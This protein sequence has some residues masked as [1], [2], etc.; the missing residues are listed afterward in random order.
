[1]CFSATA[2]FV[3]AGVTGAIGIAALTRARGVRE[4]PLAATP[5]LFAIQQGIEGLLWLDLSAAPG[6]ATADT[7]TY[8]FLLIAEVFWPVYAPVAVLL[9]EPDRRRRLGMLV[10]LAAGI[11]VGA[12]LRWLVLARPHDAAIIDGHIVYLTAY[13]HSDMVTV[14]YF[15]ATVLALL[16][17]SHRTVIGL[18][19]V[20]LAGYAVSYFFYWQAFV[21]VWCFFAAAASVAILGHFQYARRLEAGLNPA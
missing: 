3:T 15:L 2:S 11:G 5:L 8:L 21:S 19:A 4:M 20:I 1:M 18:G 17:S 16:L 7:L 13:S 6:G 9:I 12:Y 14:A 10:C